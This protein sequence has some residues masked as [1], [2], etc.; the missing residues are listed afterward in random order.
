MGCPCDQA[1]SST[2]KKK[3]IVVRSPDL[4]EDGTKPKRLSR[5]MVFDGNYVFKMEPSA[6][7]KRVMRKKKVSKILPG[8]CNRSQIV[9]KWR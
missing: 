4:D 3:R 1:S 9:R 6:D 2:Y 8:F 7:S 5:Q